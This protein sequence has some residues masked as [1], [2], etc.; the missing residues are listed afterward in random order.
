MDLRAFK[1]SDWLKM[2][3]GA[4]FLIAGP[5]TWWK[6]SFEGGSLFTTSANAHGLGDYFGTV[7]IAWLIFIAIAVL[8]V[9]LRLGMLKLP[10]SLPVPLVFLAAAALGALLVLFRFL[11]DGI[12]SGGLEDAGLDISRGLGAWLGLIATV[13]VVAGCVMGFTESGG[14]L[15]DL[16]DVDKLKSEFGTMT[17]ALGG[18]QSTPLAPPA[19]P[20]APGGSSTPPPPMPVGSSMPPPPPPPT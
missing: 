4:L 3:G 6:L 12:D 20:A 19:A 1:P 15:A 18:S 5:L 17:G 2:G 14:N 10:S 11:F 16:K 13:A 9:L 7:G 8:T